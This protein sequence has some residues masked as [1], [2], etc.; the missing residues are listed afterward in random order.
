MRKHIITALAVSLILSLFPIPMQSAGARPVYGMGV[1][2]PSREEA[3]SYPKAPVRRAAGIPASVD[4]SGMFPPPG[5]QG[6]QLSCAGWALGYAMMSYYQNKEFNRNA[7]LP[8]NQMSPS[9]IYNQINEGIDDGAH[10]SDALKL[11][12]THGVCSLKSMPYN[13]KDFS[14]QPSY[15]QHREALKYKI[16][17]WGYIGTAAQI[18]AYLAA[19]DVVTLAFPVYEDFY[20]LSAGNPIYGAYKGKYYGEHAVCIV[21]YD[22]ARGAFK[23]V[24]SWGA[25]WGLSGYAYIA[26]DLVKKNIYPNNALKP[27]YAYVITD[28][29]GADEE[30]DFGDAFSNAFNWQID[31]EET[32]AVSGRVEVPGFSWPEEPDTSFLRDADMFAFTAPR[33]G[34]LHVWSA[35]SAV[36]LTGAMYEADG[37]ELE[38][39]YYFSDIDRDFTFECYVLQDAKYYIECGVD[40]SGTGSYVLNALY[41][42]DPVRETPE[43]TPTAENTPA[44]T[45]T[46]TPAPAPSPTPTPARS[47]IP[48][49]TSP[50]YAAVISVAAAQKTVY[51]KK[52]ASAALGAVPNTADGSKAALTWKSNAPKI[53]SVDKN[54]RVKALKPGK[55]IITASAENGKSAVF[56]VIVGGRPPAA[57]S[58]KNPPAQKTMKAGDVLKLSIA[59]KP[60]NAQGVLIFKS[61]SPRVLSVDAAGQLR[62]LKKGSALITVSLGSKKTAL[63]ITVK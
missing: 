9:Y 18:K 5:N 48:F 17:G 1:I 44:P 7:K 30:D 39:D 25:K 31:A 54:G 8:A 13:E 42:E 16:K 35:G 34:T 43:P 22:D 55:A 11:L 21:G 56:T 63:K 41:V 6:S 53:I 51:L 4:L 27:M 33:D 47:P 14:A 45:P 38:Y 59:V 29:T 50:D 61:G 36:N 2:M 12:F 26:Y 23:A 60:V 49:P 58:I 57:V 37:S 28:R 15:M 52:G 32:T 19:G 46:V 3:A 10:I 40:E 24:N 20:N 62:A